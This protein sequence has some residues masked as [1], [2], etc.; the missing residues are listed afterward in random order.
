M[1]MIVLEG[2]VM[3]VLEIVMVDILVVMGKEMINKGEMVGLALGW[4]G[5]VVDGG[6]GARVRRGRRR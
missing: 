3:R 1:K 6:R 5:S 2:E 4:V